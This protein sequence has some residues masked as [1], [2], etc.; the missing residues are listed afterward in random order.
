MNIEKHLLVEGS[1]DNY[2]IDIS[3]AT[4]YGVNSPRKDSGTLQNPDTVVLHYTASN[5]INSDIRTLYESTKE[6]SVQFLVDTD[7]KVYQLM[8]ANR[9]AWHAGKSRLGNRTGMNKYSIGIEIV[10]PGYL[11]QKSDGSLATWY[12]EAVKPE[13]AIKL[14]HK[15]ENFE[16][17]WHIYTHGQID[18]VKELCLALCE[19]YNINNIVGHDDV[20]PGRKQDPGPAFPLNNITTIVLDD[21]NESLNLVEKEKLYSTVKVDNLNIRQNGNANAKKVALPLAKGQQLRIIE[22]KNGWCKV[23]TTITG[24]VKSD[25]ID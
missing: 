3:R 1:S 25:Y 14:Q 20:S 17:F 22:E 12:N 2:Q 5:N 4:N 21:R 9:I 19:A 24:W 15:N 8:P 16:R 6:A 13:N 7:G 10:N 23:E 18:S 11:V